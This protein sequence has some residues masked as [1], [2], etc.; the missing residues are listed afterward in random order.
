MDSVAARRAGEMLEAMLFVPML[1]PM[2]AGAGTLG[3]YELDL[4]AQEIA[5][6]DRA[7]FAALIATQLES[8][9]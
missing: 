7:G 6:H 8:R 2:I 1:R 3:D 9:R 5:R 4:L